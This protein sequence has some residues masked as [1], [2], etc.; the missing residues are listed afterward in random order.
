MKTKSTISNKSIKRQRIKTYFLEAAKEIIINDG[1]E[2]VSVRKVADIAGYSYPIM[3]KYFDDLNDLLWDVKETMIK[4][5][6][7]SLYSQMPH[8]LYDIH[9]INKLFRIYIAYYLNNPNIFKFFYFHQLS[10]PSKNTI[11]INSEINFADMWKETF[12]GF[13]LKGKLQETEIEIVAKIFIYAIHGLL[14]LYFSNNGE[15]TEEIIYQDVEKMVNCL[16]Q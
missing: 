11:D 2:H 8:E 3:Y 12:K 16:L 13:V 1:H 7:E 9:I 4:D 10:N 5:L 14:T 6:V 15:L